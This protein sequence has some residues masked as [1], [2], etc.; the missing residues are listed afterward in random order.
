MP[1]QFHVSHIY[2]LLCI[3]QMHKHLKWHI[4]VVYGF[5]AWHCDKHPHRLRAISIFGGLFTTVACWCYCR[6]Y[7]SNT[8]PGKTANFAFSLSL[9]SKT[10]PFRWKKIWK[11][12]CIIC[13]LKPKW[14]WLK[15]YVF[16]IVL[17]LF[18]L[19]PLYILSDL[20]KKKIY[21]HAWYLHKKIRTQ[22]LCNIALSAFLMSYIPKAM[23][24][25]LFFMLI[26][27]TISMF[28]CF[29]PNVFFF[30]Y[31]SIISWWRVCVTWWTMSI[32]GAYARY[33]STFSSLNTQMF[34]TSDEQWHIGLHIR[35]NA[36][37]GTTKS[38]ASRASIKQKRDAWCGK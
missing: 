30:L 18:Y 1:S 10:I 3:T 8:A 38:N 28:L 5:M 21:I 14:R 2:Q 33:I 15:W 26:I 35:A 29:L 32:F 6:S 4:I 22:T 27:W 36:Y 17:V 31:S 7:W 37:D 19:F 25:Q 24:A 23:P 11:H 34:D 16:N 13:V 9:K 20:L 12:F